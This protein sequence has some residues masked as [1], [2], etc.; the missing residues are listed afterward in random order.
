MFSVTPPRD[1]FFCYFCAPEFTIPISIVLSHL[2][3]KDAVK[4]CRCHPR[5]FFQITETIQWSNF[6]TYTKETFFLMIHPI[7]NRCHILHKIFEGV[8]IQN[9]IYSG[10]INKGG[11]QIARKNIPDISLTKY[12]ISLTFFMY[13][14]C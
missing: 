7:P 14:P 6:I 8:Y 1:L 10:D 3:R 12:K 11:H 2:L 4:Y 13:F 5:Y 9:L